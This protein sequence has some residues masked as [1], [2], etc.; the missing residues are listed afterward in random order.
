VAK[1]LRMHHLPRVERHGVAERPHDG[2]RHSGCVERRH[3]RPTSGPKVVGGFVGPAAAT[4]VTLPAQQL[5]GFART[6]L[7]PGASKTMTFTVPMSVLGYTGR[8]GEFV[9]EPGPVELS[10]GSSSDDLRSA[11]TF[12]IT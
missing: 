8:S 7:E 10:A 5:V 11:A 1:R 6:E 9:I 2:A 12:T 4:G 3:D